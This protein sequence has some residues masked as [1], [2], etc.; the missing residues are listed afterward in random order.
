MALLNNPAIK[1]IHCLGIGGIGVS[2]IAEFLMRKGYVISGSDVREGSN[3]KRLK[4]L[5][6]HYCHGHCE[7]NIRD[8][9]A[10]IYSSAIAKQN[11]ELIAAESAGI[12]V[13][14]RGQLLAELMQSEVSIAVS[15]THGKTTTSALAAHMLMQAGVEPTYVIGGVLNNTES[16]VRLGDDHYFVVE[17]DESDASFLHL[18]PKIAIVTNIDED[19][20]NAYDNN[21]DV[22]KACF[23]KFLNRLP[24]DG[25]AILC[26]D[27]PVIRALIPKI[28]S[29]ILTY[30]FNPDADI[31]ATDF[32]S[33]GLE[34]SI[35]VNREGRAPVPLKLNLLPGQ[36]NILNALAVVSLAVELN[37]S[38]QLLL[39]AFNTFPG[40]RRRFFAHGDITL[41]EGCALLFEDYG[42]H[43]CEVK[44]TLLAVKTAWPDRRVVL[45]FQPHRYTRTKDCW[46]QFIDVLSESDVLVLSDIYAAGEEVI[47]G[48]SAENLSQA[49]EAAGKIKPWFVPEL[50][51]LPKM[52]KQLLRPNDIVLLQGAGNIGKIAQQLV[53]KDEC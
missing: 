25:L 44:A 37:I 29:R 39:P 41:Q 50:A 27:D 53:S 15:G 1:R 46:Q 12:P 28:T 5:G 34:T 20:L 45:V 24:D 4:K 6:I 2:G 35:T 38:D 31:R 7:D 49:I 42:H 10:V 22:L 43:P 3:I 14:R 8:A 33:R 13:I 40:V 18:K 21:F 11:P 36:H 19:H 48:I 26:I 47:E 30:G 17:A 9:D 23:L 51:H 32:V 52:L 16:N